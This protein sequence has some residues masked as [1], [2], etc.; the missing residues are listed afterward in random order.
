[1]KRARR[2][3]KLRDGQWSA[4]IRG[5]GGTYKHRVKCCDCGLVH[6]V[7][8]RVTPKGLQFRAWRED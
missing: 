1:V 4:P 2:Y 3:L 6:V 8:E 7:E 5:G